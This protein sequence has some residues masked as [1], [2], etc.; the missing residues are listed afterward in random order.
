VLF[1]EITGDDYLFI[2]PLKV[3]SIN[4]FASKFLDVTFVKK[5]NKREVTMFNQII[6][7]GFALGFHILSPENQGRCHPANDG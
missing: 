1:I 4:S 5:E 6:P 3:T 2:F 7:R